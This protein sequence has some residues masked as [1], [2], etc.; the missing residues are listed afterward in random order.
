M[1][2]P[3]EVSNHAFAKAVMGGYNMAMVDEFL[4][5]LTDDYTSLYKENAALKA[6]M[7]VLVDKVEEYRSTEDAMRAALLTAQK[8]ADSMVAEAEEK[9]KSLLENAESEANRKIGALRDEVAQEERRLTAA[10]AETADFLARVR[11]LYEREM[12]LLEEL[13]EAD[14]APRL[15]WSSPRA[16]PTSAR[17]KRASWIPSSSPTS[18]RRRRS[19]RRPRKRPRS[20][21]KARRRAIPSSIPRPA[22]SSSA[23]SSSAATTTAKNKTHFKRAALS[24]PLFSQ[25]D[26]MTKRP[27]VAFL[28][29]FDKTLCT[30][31]M[32]DYA[33]IP[34]LG[35]TPSEFWAKANGFGYE[36]KMDGLLAYM[37][38]MIRE[39]AAQGI[40]L[41]RDYLVRSGEAIELFPGVREW[42]AR[43]T[44]YGADL[45]VDVEH[46]VISSGLREI[47][48][49]SG[50][51][52]EFKQIYAC[53]FYYDE[54]G[55]AAWPKL[56][57]NFTNKTQFVYRI[58]KGILDIARDKEL[59]DSMPDDSK[60]VPFTNMVY[61]GDGLSDVPC[62]KMMRAY[63]G[64]AVAVYQKSNRAGV[65]KLLQD[66]RVDFIFPADYREGTEFDKT[67]HNILRKMAV[68]DALSE[69]NAEQLRA[70]GQGDDPDQV[71]LF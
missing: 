58:N 29:D 7:K 41:D 57:V 16:P 69:K 68:S 48:E 33:F 23:T 9:K 12:K 20:R 46:Y 67:V 5:E 63:G 71:M 52:H 18:R 59:N 11:E 66:G 6:K 50:I 60:R 26:T 34:S 31:D 70:I 4:D 28:Y 43:I 30:T 8:M 47:I 24:E 56:D 3:Q 61:V 10:K 19:S 15:R 49:G 51:A 38:T 32:E 27:I 64:Q 14:L 21:R 39:C 54:S 44:A 2:T 40:R 37:Y 62:M 25:E 36:N 35:Y 45:G 42:F 13:P 17:S 1:L 53:E 22:P 65:E 55:L